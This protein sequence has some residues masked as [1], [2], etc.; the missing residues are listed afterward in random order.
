MPRRAMPDLPPDR[1]EA[2]ATELR[3]LQRM[4]DRAATDKHVYI[5]M[6]VEAGMSEREIAT[7]LKCSDSSAHRWKVLGEKER[8]RQRE[9]AANAASGDPEAA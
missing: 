5:A 1:R 9:Q 2:M 3:V 6:A 7:I 4:E 8:E